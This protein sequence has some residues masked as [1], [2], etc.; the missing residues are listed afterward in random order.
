MFGGERAEVASWA[1]KPDT[2][3]ITTSELYCAIMGDSFGIGSGDICFR[4]AMVGPTS[5][6]SL[7]STP[8]DTRRI[9]E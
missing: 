7:C 3:V 5:T 6:F 9:V 4:R 1:V 2:L 8:L